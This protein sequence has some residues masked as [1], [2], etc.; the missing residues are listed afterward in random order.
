MLQPSAAGSEQA[1]EL[2]VVSRDSMEFLDITPQYLICCI[3]QQ[4]ADGR[5]DPLDDAIQ[6]SLVDGV[7]DILQYGGY[8]LFRSADLLLGLFPLADLFLQFEVDGLG[9]LP[10]LLG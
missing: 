6:V 1:F 7:L 8:A 4:L 10:G 9:I 2:V 3:A 5:S